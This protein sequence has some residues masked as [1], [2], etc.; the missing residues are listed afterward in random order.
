MNKI[1]TRSL[2]VSSILLSS[3]VA[4]STSYKQG[5]TWYSG[6]EFGLLPDQAFSKTI[7]KQTASDARIEF[8]TSGNI[9]AY[10]YREFFV[11]NRA[12]KRTF[13]SSGAGETNKNGVSAALTQDGVIKTIIE[14]DKSSIN[15]GSKTTKYALMFD[16]YNESGTGASGLVSKIYY[17]TAFKPELSI[18]QAWSK[19]IVNYKNTYDE[20][21]PKNYSKAIYENFDVLLEPDQIINKNSIV[22][23]KN[24]RYSLNF[25][26]TG[27]LT[28]LD[29]SE[30]ILD[31]RLSSNI[32]YL[33]LDTSLMYAGDTGPNPYR[34]GLSGY[35]SNNQYVKLPFLN[36]SYNIKG[37]L[38]VSN[39]TKGSAIFIGLE[40]KFPLKSVDLFLGTTSGFYSNKDCTN[41]PSPAESYYYVGRNG[42]KCEYRKF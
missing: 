33:K 27:R 9:V 15:P 7:N 3:T 31:E 22:K 26:S 36:I 25:D 37:K 6:D 21:N 38:L 40:Q 20:F 23:S 30:I 16:T 13:F 10:D 34:R 42:G 35:D 17:N 14:N 11:N 12:V 2:L 5:D 39:N 41:F 8:L 18:I 29:G 32:A 1:F 28:I 4:N 24:S 19:P